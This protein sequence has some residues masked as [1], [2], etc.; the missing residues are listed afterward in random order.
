MGSKCKILFSGPPKGTSLRE[1]ASFEVLILKIGAGVLAVGCRKNQKK[2][3]RVTWCAFSHI[4]G[5]KRGNRIKMKFCIRVG[6]PDV[7]THAN[8]GDDR[9]RCFWGSGGRIS[10]FSIDLRTV[11]VLKTGSG[12][13]TGS[14]IY[15]QT[16]V[17]FSLGVCVTTWE[18]SVFRILFTSFKWRRE[19][20]A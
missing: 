10:H 9:F 13:V 17:Y 14:Y 16:L 2:I 3:S 6:V 15:R 18:V 7:I 5:A 12:L 1:T 4:W 20:T 8:F 19:I 11:V